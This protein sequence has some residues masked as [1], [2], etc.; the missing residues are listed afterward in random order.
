MMG[1]FV[2][3]EAST[4][5][6]SD[7]GCSDGIK[8]LVEAVSPIPSPRQPLSTRRAGVEGAWK[9]PEHPKARLAN[10]ITP[11]PVKQSA[12]RKVVSPNP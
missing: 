4:E 6:E 7:S 8:R 12:A 1:A 11:R 2:E 9:R 10:T 3:E 5:S